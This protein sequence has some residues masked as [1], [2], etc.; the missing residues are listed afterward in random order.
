MPFGTL[1]P[2]RRSIFHL[3]CRS[4]GERPNIHDLIQNVFRW[5]FSQHRKA[6]RLDELYAPSCQR[7]TRP[8]SFSLSLSLAVLYIRTAFHPVGAPS[9]FSQTVS[10]T[11]TGLRT[12]K[13][14]LIYCPRTAE[15]FSL[16]GPRTFLSRSLSRQV[17]LVSESGCTLFRFQALYRK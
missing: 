2:N 3:F 9:C 12:G 5:W 4:N 11:S 1:V 10:D 8:A 15:H 6:I 13:G 14:N 16:I 17:A 7:L